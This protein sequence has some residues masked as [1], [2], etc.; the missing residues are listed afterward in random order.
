MQEDQT[1]PTLSGGPYGAADWPGRGLSHP[2]D[3]YW[4]R[5]LDLYRR[6]AISDYD[7]DREGQLVK[8]HLHTEGIVNMHMESLDLELRLLLS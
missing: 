3:L 6:A 5:V 4:D 1:P 8:A 2:D 7:Y